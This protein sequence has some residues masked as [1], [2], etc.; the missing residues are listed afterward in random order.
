[1]L[2][3]T[4]IFFLIALSVLAVIHNIAIKLFL[5]WHIWW[6]DIPIHALGGTV[7]AL[8]L[9]AL[10]D[11]KLF[12]N[13]LLKPLSVMGL[14]LL[15]AIIWEVFEI[16]AGIP[17][18]EHYVLDTI[19]DVSMGLLGGYIGYIVGNNLRKLR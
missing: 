18:E 17:M 15:V 19:I 9:F 3:L 1:M 5:Y 6:L 8:G 11:L 7:V 12:P 13:A 2:Q 10:R 4:T 16:V 14:V